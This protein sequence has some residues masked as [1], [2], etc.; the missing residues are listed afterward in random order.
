MCQRKKKK[1]RRS[2]VE[3]KIEGPRPVLLVDATRAS[4]Y[5]R[6]QSNL[7]ASY[8]CPLFSFPRGRITTVDKLSAF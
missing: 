2:V 7:I 8:L 5:R 4:I 1:T 3:D 6:Q